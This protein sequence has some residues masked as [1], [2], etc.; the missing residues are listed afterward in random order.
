M[1]ILIDF[2]IKN[3][4]T[5]ASF[6]LFSFCSNTNLIEKTAGTSGIWTRIVRVE[7]EHFNHLTT[8]T[9]Q[10]IRTVNIQR[11]NEITA[12]TSATVT[13]LIVPTFLQWDQLIN[14]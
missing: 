5:P 13:G 12:R 10:Y 4:P 9:A 8:T 2:F 11:V 6:C 3:E 1:N 14:C 7:G